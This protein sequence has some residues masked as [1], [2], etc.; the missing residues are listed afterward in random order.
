MFSEREV[1]IFDQI[2]RLAKA[3]EV[4]KVVLFGSRARRTH[5]EKSDI[6]L[7]VYGCKDFAN[8]SFDMEEQVWTLLEFDLVDM[9]LEVSEELQKEIERDGKILYEKI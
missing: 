1:K 7:A 5:Q 6:D 9:E 3:Y 4:K 8:F 2:V